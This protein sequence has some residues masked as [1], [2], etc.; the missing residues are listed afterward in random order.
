MWLQPG[1]HADGEPDVYHVALREAEEETGLDNLRPVQRDIFD[2]D[3]HT[4]PP[5]REVAEH[6]HY[7]I[8]FLFTVDS[9]S[10]PVS[11]SESHEVRWVRIGDILNFTHEKSILRMIRKLSR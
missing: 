1:G 3:I 10:V 9:D 7:D 8:R 4:I 2:L 5:Y 11:S 6:L